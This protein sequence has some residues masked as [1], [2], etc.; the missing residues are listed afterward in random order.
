[1]KIFDRTI[2]SLIVL[3]SLPILLAG[4][5]GASEVSFSQDV[6]PILEQNC[7]KCHQEGGKG[8]EASGFSMTT[9]A[10]LMKGTRFGP[11]IIAGDTLSSN[12]VVL[13]EGRADPSIRMPFTHGKWKSIARQDIETIKLWIEQG[14][15]N[16]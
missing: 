1:M 11:M 12:L 8:Q 6:K 15:K 2:G 16:N 3:G 13:M 14:A 9:Y 5:S 4:C 7:I 10:D